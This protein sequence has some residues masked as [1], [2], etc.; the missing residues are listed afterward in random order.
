[1]TAHRLAPS[2]DALL[3]E[4]GSQLPGSP[5]ER[6]LNSHVDGEMAALFTESSS[7]VLLVEAASQL[8][9]SHAR[10]GLMAFGRDAVMT[11]VGFCAGARP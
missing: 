9:A 3:Y 4:S 11:N 8:F 2:A 5:L 10:S 7:T 6:L 1:M